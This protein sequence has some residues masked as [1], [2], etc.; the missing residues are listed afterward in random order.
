MNEAF[1]DRFSRR[2]KKSVR[3]KLRRKRTIARE[4]AWLIAH[5]ID[6]TES[7]APVA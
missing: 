4:T 3:R 2:K 1:A 7:E 6:P 5:G